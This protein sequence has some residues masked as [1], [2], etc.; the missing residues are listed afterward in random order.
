MIKLIKII[1]SIF[2]FK[3]LTANC[4]EGY[5]DI[6]NQ[7]YF[8]SDLE[9]INIF[10]QNSTEINYILDL[11]NNNVIEPLEFCSQIWSEN[12]RLI[13]LDC[14]PIIIDGVYNWLEISGE[15][16]G[17]IDTWDA[18]EVLKLPY[19]NLNGF[20]PNNIC[21]LNLE[22]NNPAIFSLEGN[23]LCPPYPECVEDY[24]GMQSNFGTGFCELGNCYNVG[25]SQMTL[26]ELN[27]DNLVN[28][29]NDNSGVAHL[30]VNVHNDGPDC[31]TYPGLL[32]TANIEGTNL[33]VLPSESSINWWYAIPANYTYFSD[34]IIDISPYIP[35]DT[36]L[37]VTAELVTMNCLDESCSEDPYCHDCPETE[38]ASISVNIGENYPSRLGDINFDN[39]IN[40]IDIIIIVSFIV[41]DIN[42]YYDESNSIELYLSDYNL[43]NEINILDIIELVN[44]ILNN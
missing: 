32:I 12:G 28:P 22:F 43:D 2:L 14:N 11:N 16:T 35:L 9:V 23:D 8:E 44:I 37:I 15:I 13:S 10:L 27:G 5:I 3:L 39:Q 4:Q 21:N 42:N 19:N 20:V 1:L 31:S 7:C 18:I 33:P 29:Y 6:E 40:I 26:I 24:M 34:I 17:L 30:L 41:N 38:P 25:V 36:E